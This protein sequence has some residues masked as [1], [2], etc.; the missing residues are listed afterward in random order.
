MDTRNLKPILDWAKTTDLDEVSF[1]RHGESIEFQLEGAVSVPDS[2]FPPC[3]L[4]PVTA[5][6]VGIF[7]AD[8]Q[9]KAVGVEEGATVKPGQVLGYIETGKSRHP[10]KADQGGKVVSSKV[11]DGQPVEFGQPLYFIQPG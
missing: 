2:V 10:V 1:R 3:S 11:E 8:G 6:E 5:R 4:A 7:R 9:G